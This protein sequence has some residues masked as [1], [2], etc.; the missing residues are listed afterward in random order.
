MLHVKLSCSAHRLEH[1]WSKELQDAK[2]PTGLGSN[3]KNGEEVNFLT[4]ECVCGY[5][6]SRRSSGSGSDLGYIGERGVGG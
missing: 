2:A 1:R 3:L 5:G 4:D 6:R